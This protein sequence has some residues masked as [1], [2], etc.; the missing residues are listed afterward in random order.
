MQK[1]KE[2]EPLGQCLQMKGK[3]RKKQNTTP[4]QRSDTSLNTTREDTM[5]EFGV[6]DD[7]GNCDY[8]ELEFHTTNTLD[9]C[10]EVI[11]KIKFQETG[12]EKNQ[13]NNW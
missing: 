10:T 7:T 8:R 4:Y 5:K 1:M 3:S 12:R 11:T 9:S 6:D 2:M 13:R